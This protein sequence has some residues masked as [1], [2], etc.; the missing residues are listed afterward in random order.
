MCDGVYLLV[1]VSYPDRRFHAQK[2]DA[3]LWYAFAVIDPDV[4]VFVD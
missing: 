4:E 1:Q 2:F 3:E